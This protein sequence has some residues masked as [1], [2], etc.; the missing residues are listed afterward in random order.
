[1]KAIVIKAH[2]G[3]ENL[4]IR[5]LPDPEPRPGHVVIEV[6][7]FGVNHAETHMRQGQWPEIAEVSGIEC[8]GLVKADPDGKLAA[9]QK[10]A[11]LMG[12]M[13]RTIY[14]SYAEYTNVPAS[15]VVP[16]DTSLP[17]AD[18]AAIPESYATAWTCLHGNLELRAGQLLVLR[19]ATS[20]LGQAALNIAARAGATVIA[21]TRNRERFSKLEGLGAN[22]VLLEGPELARRVRERHPNGVDAVL[23]LVGNGVVLDSLQAVR[24]G[25]RVCEAGWLGG[26]APIPSFNPMLQ[27]PSGVHFSLFGSFVFGSVEFPLSDVPLQAIVD[28]VATG[29]YQAKPARVFRFTEI[30]EAHR[31]ME[32][33]QANGKIVVSL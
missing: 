9:G 7:A 33:N 11:A 29:D 31:L 5:E 24:R 21:T 32:S 17:W 28:R 6:K 15:N 1:M 26:L 3:P 4:V 23:D 30:Q 27:V 14:G 12:G 8:V 19:G 10:V 18:L 13:G 2:G 16:L 20:A 25:G 22:G